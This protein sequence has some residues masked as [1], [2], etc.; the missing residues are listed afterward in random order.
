MTNKGRN[1]ANH[2]VK[3]DE[4]VL[5]LVPFFDENWQTPPLSRIALQSYLTIYCFCK[6]GIEIEISWN[7]L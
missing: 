1:K 5:F 4:M 2:P 6:P 3:H 7:V